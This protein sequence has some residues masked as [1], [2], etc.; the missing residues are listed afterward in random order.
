MALIVDATE[1]K[2]TLVNQ[3][4]TR[5]KSLG[6]KLNCRLEGDPFFTLV[7]AWAWM[8]S[9]AWDDL[10]AVLNAYSP[11]TGS[12]AALRETLGFFELE[13]LLAKSSQQTFTIFRKDATATKTIPT[14]AAIQTKQSVLG[15][16]RTYK[17]KTEGLTMAV[18]QYFA[19][20]TFE[21]VET[22]LVT[23]ITTPQ[24]MEVVSSIAGCYV[25]AGSYRGV[26][27]NPL[28][29]M[30][31][32]F[33]DW[34]ADNV[35]DVRI[36]FLVEGR[37][38]ETDDE[39]RARCFARWDEQAAGATAASYESWAKN[40]VDPVTGDSPVVDAKVT[41]NQVFNS[42]VSVG[43]TQ[44][45][46][47][48][49]LSNGQEYVMAVEIA[50]ALR[51]GVPPTEE[52]RLAIA[53]D[54]LPKMPHTDIVWL[55]GPNIVT[56]GAGS[57]AITYKGP[58][59]REEEVRVVAQSFFVLDDAYPDNYQ[60]LG[61]EIY[62]AELIHAI[63]QI[64]PLIENV[65]VIFTAAGKVDSDGDLILDDFD[66]CYMATPETAIVVT[67]VPVI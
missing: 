6:S 55:R 65:K 24:E 51:S 49:P 34:L 12:G 47:G 56:L 63:K 38:D 33:S 30:T 57:V 15:R 62:K 60:G 53:T 48:G 46:S 44:R 41:T 13:P 42:T 64:D 37:D 59:S 23:S 18:G 29:A 66:Q 5:L 54:M 43:P 50:I 10:L 26:A 7:K 45:A 27:T 58:A 3:F 8:L 1:R 21:A 35:A 2:E 11:L 25:A 32:T 17:L 31:G 36:V 22:G 16:V 28:S 61:A 52:I 67:I 39:Y 9:D 4:F 40:Y 20:L 19:E 14:G